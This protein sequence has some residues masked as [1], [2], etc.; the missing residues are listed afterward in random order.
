MKTIL[1]VKVLFAATVIFASFFFISSCKKDEIKPVTDSSIS[2][3]NQLRGPDRIVSTTIMHLPGLVRDAEGHLNPN[4]NPAS[5]IYNS[6]DNSPIVDTYGNIITYTTFMNVAG[7]ASIKCANGGTNVT[8][9]MSKLI[10]KGVYTLWVQTFRA[11]GFDGTMNNLVAYGR[12]DGHN[13]FKA[14]ANGTGQLSVTVPAGPMSMTPWASIGDCL[15]GSDDEFHIVG[16]YQ[17]NGETY[18]W[19]PGREGLFVEHFRFSFRK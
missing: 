12:A 15:T 14:S 9:T 10:P 16:V 19:T 3:E 5:S 8:V 18:G 17:T 4:I 13:D 1:K 7:Q 11:P 6:V 2:Q